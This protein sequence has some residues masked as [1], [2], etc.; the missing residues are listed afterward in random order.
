MSLKK[1][2][3]S[4]HKKSY[5]LK[6]CEPGFNSLSD[7][8]KS[9]PDSV[10]RK[11]AHF[12]TSILSLDA[13]NCF[14][15]QAPKTQT[16]FIYL[17]RKSLGFW[18]LLSYWFLQSVRLKQLVSF[19]NS[20]TS[21]L[22]PESPKIILFDAWNPG[23]PLPKDKNMQIETSFA[24]KLFAKSEKRPF[25]QRKMLVFHVVSATSTHDVDMI[26]FLQ[27]ECPVYE[28]DAQRIHQTA[29]QFAERHLPSHEELSFGK[30]ILSFVSFDLGWATA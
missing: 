7:L 28:F 30:E 16:Q 27:P 9:L 17:N 3:V 24:T 8:I 18:E 25:F 29:S 4:Y 10:T 19:E 12:L 15:S 23:I 14:I 22:L 1:N 2:F 5:R 21:R 13:E 20:W 6:T 26:R 11:S